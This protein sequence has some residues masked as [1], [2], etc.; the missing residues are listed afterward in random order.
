MS[1]ANY[2]WVGMQLKKLGYKRGKCPPKNLACWYGFRLNN[3]ACP[4]NPTTLEDLQS[5]LS[6]L[7]K[8]LAAGAQ[9]SDAEW[10][11][12]INTATQKAMDIQ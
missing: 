6:A 7:S 3:P 5:Y 8:N 11:S 9:Y 2:S 12:L 1:S 10:L 4:T